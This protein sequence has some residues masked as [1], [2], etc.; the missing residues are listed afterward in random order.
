MSPL[1]QRVTTAV[2]VVPPLVA[3]ILLLPTPAFAVLAGLIIL[4]A[5]WEWAGLA[6][7]HA[8]PAR[9]AYGLAFV[10]LSAGAGWLLAQPGGPGPVLLAGALWWLLAT[11]LVVADQRGH[12]L[13]PRARA[14][15]GGVGLLA[16]VPAWVALVALHRQPG[17]G[18][19]LVLALLVLVWM[20]DTAAFFVGR[21]WGRTRLAPRLSPNKS[22]EGVWG[23]VAAAVALALAVGLLAGLGGGQLALLLALAAVTALGSVVGDLLE[24]L[25]K[26]RAG[27]KDSGAVLPGHGGMLDR[28]DSLTSAAPLFAAG[29]YGM[30]RLT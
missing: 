23:G 10:L 6:R 1:A 7:L 24:S 13:L 29:L 16:L 26:R 15:A 18:P 14:V 3:A 27:V 20:A 12:S 4:L 9:A 25:F 17:E 8:A 2:L 21:R 30:G 22:W 5:A 28:I 19:W 11:A